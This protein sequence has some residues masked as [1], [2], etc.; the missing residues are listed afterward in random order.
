MMSYI[1]EGEQ[2]ARWLVYLKRFA[3]LNFDLSTHGEG[4]EQGGWVPNGVQA[5]QP[6]DAGCAHKPPPAPP[7][8]R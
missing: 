3:K 8:K 2:D 4:G 5:Q 1:A 6:G 7:L